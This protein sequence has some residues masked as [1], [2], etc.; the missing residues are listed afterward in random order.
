MKTCSVSGCANEQAARGLCHN[1]YY[2]FRTYGSALAVPREK[3]LVQAFLDKALLTETDACVE[4]PWPRKGDRYGKMLYNGR[5]ERVHVVVCTIKHGRKPSPKHV[6]AHKCGK[7]NCINYRH[8]RW[9]TQAQNVEDAV[10]HGSFPRGEQR[11]HTKLTNDEARRILLLKGKMR[12]SELARR[13]GV[14]DSCIRSIW[15][16]R[17]WTWLGS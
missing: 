9:A 14:T 6:A 1:H 10:R 12:Q 5:S 16:G 11:G 17:T 15:R 3:H 8:L 7:H 4:W 2:R 13:Y